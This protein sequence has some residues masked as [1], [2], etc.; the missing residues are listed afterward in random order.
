MCETQEIKHQ[1]KDRISRLTTASS[2]QTLIRPTRCLK[3]EKAKPR[4][5]REK[6]ESC[7]LRRLLRPPS[8]KPRRCDAHVSPTK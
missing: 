7:P 3:K 4:K 8:A 6:C 5:T 1:T 2:P